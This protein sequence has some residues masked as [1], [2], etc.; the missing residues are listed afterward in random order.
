MGV[1]ALDRQAIPSE[2]QLWTLPDYD[3]FLA[4]R[5]ELVANRLNEFLG[6]EAI[7]FEVAE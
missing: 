4:K 1:E 2:T 6:H 5:R 3:A 7:N